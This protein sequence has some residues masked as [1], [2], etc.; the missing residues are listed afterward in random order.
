MTTRI[1]D[2]SN[3]L[4]ANSIPATGSVPAPARERQ[5]GAK[6]ARAEIPTGAFRLALVAIFTLS[7]VLQIYFNFFAVHVNNHGSC[8]ASEYLR[9]AKALIKVSELPSDRWGNI[10][11]AAC[12]MASPRELNRAKEDLTILEEMHQSGPVFPLFLATSFCASGAGFSNSNDAPP[13]AAQSLL[14]ALACVFLALT[15]ELGWNRRTAVIAGVIGALYPAFIVNSGRLYSES[16]ATFLISVA[17]YLTASLIVRQRLPLPLLFLAGF[18][19]ACLHLTRSIM[20]VYTLSFL[21]LVCIMFWRR[22]WSGTGTLAGSAKTLVNPRLLGDLIPVVLGMSLV[23]LPWLGA[24]KIMFDKPAFVIDRV[25][26]YNMFTG[27]H[28]ESAGWL[29]YPY[30]DGHGLETKSFGKLMKEAI[31]SDPFG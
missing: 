14:A 16:F 3:G 26:N 25:G 2:V 31:K 27:N 13:L 8:D 24:T 6:E 19:L 17:L 5:S 10:V 12:G 9:N 15:V 11:R 28:V 22:H 1:P 20:V 7:L 23:I 29:S 4:D 30:P 18:D 21:A